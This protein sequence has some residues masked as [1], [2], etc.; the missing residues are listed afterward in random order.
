METKDYYVLVTTTKKV[1]Y[2]SWADNPEQA[3][4]HIKKYKLGGPEK[5]FVETINYGKKDYEI[6]ERII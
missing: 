6:K 2:K 3:I 4:E 1:L 5:I